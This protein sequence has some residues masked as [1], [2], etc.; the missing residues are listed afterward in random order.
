MVEHSVH[1]RSVIGSSPIAATMGW[2]SSRFRP[3]GQVVKTPPFHG[4]NTSSTLVRVTRRR[5]AVQGVFCFSFVFQFSIMF[6][7]MPCSQPA[8]PCVR[9][10]GNSLFLPEILPSCTESPV[11]CTA[12]TFVRRAGVEYY[13]CYREHYK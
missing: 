7:N 13:K 4:G 12:E 2:H 1:T 10:R 6:I 8:R 11:C 3:V 9:L 5:P